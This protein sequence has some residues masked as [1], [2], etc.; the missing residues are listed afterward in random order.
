MPLNKA[1]SSTGSL[2]WTPECEQAYRTLKEKLTTSPVLAPFTPNETSTLTVDASGQAIGAVLSQREHPVLYVSRKLTDT[3]TRYSNI[4]REGLAIVWACQRLKH[5]LLGAKFIIQTDHKPLIHIFGPN[6]P[7]SSEVSPRLL[8]YT[9]KLMPYDYN[10]EH[11]PGDK[12]I[13]ADSLSRVYHDDHVKV[14]QV[15]FSQPCID[16]AQL[17]AEYQHDR[18]LQDLMNRIR[19]GDWS[20]VSAREKPYKKYALQLTIDN[21]GCIRLGSRVVPPQSLYKNIY[22][23]AHQSHCGIQATQKLIAQEFYWP[24][25]HHTIEQMVKSC[26]V[27]S[28]ARFRSE[29]TT[30]TWPADTVPWTRIHIDWAYH[31]RIGNILVIADSFSGWLSAAICTN[32][33]TNTVITQLRSL[34]TT[35]GVP[36][37]LVSD[38]ALEFA[39]EHFR[40][41]LQN[42]GCCLL[43]SPEYRPQSNGLAERAVRTIKDALKCYNPQK[44][45]ASAFIDRFLFVH[46]NTAMRNGKTP[47]Q[48]MLAYSTRCPILSTYEP[49]QSVLYKSHR[50]ATPKPVTYL[51][52]QG[53]NTALIAQPGQ[54]AITA[55]DAQLAEWP[56]ENREPGGDKE[57]R[58]LLRRERRRPDYYGV[59]VH[60]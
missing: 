30:H 6:N 25:M 16:V 60:E 14:P 3:E 58:E 47:S 59:P 42:I 23:I 17:K 34:F 7:V 32:R 29:D 57:Q 35:F 26:R 1:K 12:N 28:S 31:Q 50:E 13:I 52:R 10:I 43:H 49:L 22:D 51:F 21:D 36:K 5:F 45:S 15:H 4:E 54:K 55:H 37:T 44:C 20:N 56:D 18:F 24:N 38:N 2:Q 53:A 40:Q 19:T 48:L 39:N 27:C 46:H 33:S 9:L 8:K 41:W 11:V